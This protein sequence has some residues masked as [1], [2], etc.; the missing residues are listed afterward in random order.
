MNLG[1][2]RFYLFIIAIVFSS[3]VNAINY[4]SRSDGTWSNTNGGADCS[5]SP[6]SDNGWLETGDYVEVNHGNASNSSNFSVT[7]TPTI[8]INSGGKWSINGSMAI[9]GGTWTIAAHAELYINGSVTDVLANAIT[10]NGHI[11]ATGSMVNSIALT[12]SGSID[13]DGGYTENGS[14]TGITLPVELVD[15]KAK[16]AEDKVELIW[17]TESEFNSDYYS[18]L[19]SSNGSDFVTIGTKP[20]AGNSLS[21][22]K[23]SYLDYSPVRGLNYYQ[24]QE[25]DVDG[26]MQQ[27][28][29]IV[30]RV[31]PVGIFH[32]AAGQHS[33]L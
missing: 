3:G 19:R 22:L 8:V 23:Y 15:F 24:L 9:N 16:K 32:R 12:G 30:L 33:S 1:L 18:I 7:G 28:T 14:H 29:V 2:L 6:A 17:T 13:A 27:S 20:A 4:Y 5:C 26:K 31:S 10:V 11:H 25:F 21:L